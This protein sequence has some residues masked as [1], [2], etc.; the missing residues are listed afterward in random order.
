MLSPEEMFLRNS[1]KRGYLYFTD[2]AAEKQMRLMIEKNDIIE[3][4]ENGPIIEVQ[5]GYTGEQPRILVY[6]D[7]EKMFY[8]V[9]AIDFPTACIIISVIEVDFSKWNK[10][11]DSIVRK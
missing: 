6:S 4:V 2:H 5:A 8:V 3:C 7:H 10:D 1:N 9:V 11:G